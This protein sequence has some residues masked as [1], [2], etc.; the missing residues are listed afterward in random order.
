M[1]AVA[2]ERYGPPQNLE[3]TDLPDPKVGPDSVLVRVRSAGCNPVDYKI[4]G[5]GLDAFF[6]TYFPLVPGWDVAGVVESAGPA[7]TSFRPGDEVIG[8][9]RQDYV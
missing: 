3:L 5:G 1:K 7:V 9:V 8:Y 2:L 6:P 4:L